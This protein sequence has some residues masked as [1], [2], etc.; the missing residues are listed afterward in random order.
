MEETFAPVFVGYAIRAARR[1]VAAGVPRPDEDPPLVVRRAAPLPPP[2]VVVYV[3]GTHVEMSVSG[4]T[5]HIDK[6]VVRCQGDDGATYEFRVAGTCCGPHSRLTAGCDMTNAVS[7]RLRK[8][9][10]ERVNAEAAKAAE[11][12]CMRACGYSELKRLL[13]ELDKTAQRIEKV[14]LYNTRLRGL[15][16]A[17][18]EHGG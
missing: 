13:D 12:E 9:I 18:A 5:V 4:D 10:M 11:H 15:A 1:L 3:K 7:S 14:R 16:S 6:T 8:E 17:L 2:T